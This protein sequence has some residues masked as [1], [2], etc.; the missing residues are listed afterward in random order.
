MDIEKFEDFILEQLE[1]DKKNK[2][3]LEQLI[4]IENNIRFFLAVFYFKK[5]YYFIKKINSFF[6]KYKCMTLSYYTT[7]FFWYREFKKANK[8]IERGKI[9]I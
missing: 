8:I 9:N 7:C 3:T 6:K 4:R 5:D 2:K 1:Q